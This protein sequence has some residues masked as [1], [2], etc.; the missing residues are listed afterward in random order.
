MKKKTELEQQY[1][2]QKLRYD[3]DEIQR[4][5]A[6]KAIDL[7]MMYEKKDMNN[8]LYHD[9]IA[10]AEAMYNN[11]IDMLKKRQSLYKKDSQ[12]WLDIDAEISQRQREQDLDRTQRYN[13]LL[14]RYKEEWAAKDIKEQERLT[15]KGLDLLHKKGLLKEME[16]QEMLKQIKLRYAEQEAEQSLHN[17]RNEQFKRNAHSAYNTASNKAQASWSNKHD[18]GVNVGAF[19]TSDI[20]IYAS[21][22]ANIKSMEQEGLISHEEAMA[23]MGEA[24]A[25]MCNGLVA[26]MQAAMDAISPLMSA[27]SSYYSAQ[28]DYEVTITEKKYEKLI[29][30]AGNNT[31]KRKKLEEKKEKEIA[32]IKTKYAKKQAA[33]QIAQAIAQTAISAIGAYSSA[34]TGMPYP[35][36]MVLAPIAA[37]IAAAAGAI[38][39]ATIKKQQQ[40]Q[41]AG[42]YEGGF[43]GGS[44]YRRK[45][46]IVHEGEFVANHNAV[47]NPQVLPA[48]QLIDEAQRNNTVGSLTAADISRSLGQGGATVVSAPSV[49]V[50]TDN[51]ELNATLG[52]AR[53]VIDQLSLVL[54]QGIHAECYI[55]GELGIARNLDRYNKLKSHT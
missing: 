43:T 42:Y 11:D 47:N 9:D 50:N 46:G 21:T 28:S 5:H 2:Q 45:A 36:N 44:S 41:E 23:A 20:D 25:N 3:E 54:A 4:E 16:Y 31:A 40:A 18:D 34:M 22:L 13:D 14:E 55:D 12:E 38:Q 39:I 30:A 17:S 33:M 51:S 24:T 27:M 29:N 10:L 7:Q 32:K 48:L 15:L 35:A 26:K 37:G 6:V 52:E 19:I 49:T 53:D 1:Q 8:D